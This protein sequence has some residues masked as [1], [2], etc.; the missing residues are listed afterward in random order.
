METN[1]VF[2]FEI[3]NFDSLNTRSSWIQAWKCYINFRTPTISAKS[4]ATSSCFLFIV[5]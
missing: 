3:S 4:G 5:K 1:Q 2:R